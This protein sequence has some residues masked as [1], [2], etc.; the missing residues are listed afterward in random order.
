MR[1][2]G[3]SAPI[4]YVALLRGINVGGHVVKM[5]RL[6]Q[7]FTDLGL[8]NVRSYIN[9]G[10]VFFDTSD[11]DRASLTET[12]ERALHNALGYA[13]PTFLRTPA[14]L[15]AVLDRDPFA[16]V[17]KTD[18]LRF[19]VM[20]TSEPLNQELDLPVSTSRNDMDMVAVNEFEA[21]VIWR[22]ID[23]RVTGKFGADILP[24][25]NTTRFFHTLKKILAAA[26]S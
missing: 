8:A 24:T 6:R 12:I 14:E 3:P 10:N 13:V 17:A 2:T 21:Y 1:A 9:S 25:R 18:D 19:C 15:G 7:V 22:L 4:R 5:D 20:F 11:T 16:K 26:T 23:G